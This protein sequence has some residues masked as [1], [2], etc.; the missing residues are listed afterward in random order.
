MASVRVMAFQIIIYD[1]RPSGHKLK[2]YNAT[3]DCAKASE[4]KRDILQF[5]KQ[6]ET[7]CPDHMKRQKKLVRT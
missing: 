7:E 6:L 2:C 5:L 3:F 1:V 4:H